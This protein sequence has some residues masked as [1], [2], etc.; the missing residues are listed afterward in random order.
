MA[1]RID[2]FVPPGQGGANNR[3][4]G[5]IKE[6]VRNQKYRV[7]VDIGRDPANKRKQKVVIVKGT[8]KDAEKT[9]AKL[10]LDAEKLLAEAISRQATKPHKRTEELTVGDYLKEWYEALPRE[11]RENTKNYYKYLISYILET[12]ITA[13]RLVNVRPPDVQRAVNQLPARLAAATRRKACEFLRS[14]FKQALEWDMIEKN[15]FRGVKLPKT[16]PKE[17]RFWTEKE[18]AV[19]LTA[20]KGTR[21]YAAF[22]VAIA[23]GLRVGELLALTWKDVDLKKGC[24]KVSKTLL[25]AT[26]G[27]PIT[28]P[29]KTSGSNRTVFLDP[30]TV[31]V[32]KA[33]RTAQL[34]QRLKAGAK[35]QDHN[36]VFTRRNGGAMP[37]ETLNAF[38]YRQRLIPV[39][40]VHSLRHTH[41]TFLL[42]QGVPETVIA[43]RLGHTVGKGRSML[44]MTARYSHVTD[45]ARKEAAKAFARALQKGFS[46]CSG[47]VGKVGQTD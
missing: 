32:L 7:T 1:G 16:Q 42:S 21:H 29:P 3:M 15:P 47:Q 28:G 2:L 39:V 46:E 6:L 18:A 4:K 31:E 24:I 33:H 37:Y 25:S 10:V 30:G 11:L 13:L 20:A 17:S 43:D 27:K 9:L 36:L 5:S 40:S 35:W 8:R 22:Y 12:D 38:L 45:E 19:F 14:V 44:G 34:E 26:G 41:A 23:T